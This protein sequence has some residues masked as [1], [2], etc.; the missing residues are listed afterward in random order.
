MAT[1]QPQQAPVAMPTQTAGI[2][3]AFSASMQT[4]V[5][6]ALALNAIASTVNNIAQ[7]GE[8]KSSN[9]LESVKIADSMAIAVLRQQQKQQAEALAQNGVVVNDLF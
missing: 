3:T 6:S 1:Q 4:I 8:V 5:T 2:G 9:M 7:I